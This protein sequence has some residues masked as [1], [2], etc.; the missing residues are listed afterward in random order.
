MNSPIYADYNAT[1]PLAPEAFRAMEAAGKAWGNP[2]SAHGLGREAAGLVQE[3]RE[4]I[5]EICGVGRDSVVFT[6]GGSEANSAALLGKY[7]SDPNF[8]LVTSPVEHSSI[9]DTA[10][11]LAQRSP[12]Y[13]TR[14]DGDGGLDL[15]YFEQLL[16]EKKPTLVS[17]MAANNE[18]GARFDIPT[19]ADL[20][21]NRGVLFHTDAVQ[22]LGKIPSEEWNGADLIT[23]SAH[24]IHGPKGVGALILRPG[25]QLSPLHYGGSQEVKRRGG[26]ENVSGI[27]G[28]AAAARELPQKLADQARIADLRNRFESLITEQI[29]ELSIQGQGAPRV[30]NTSNLRFEGISSEVLLSALDLDAVCISAGSACSAGSIRPSHV[31]LAMGLSTDQARECLRVSFGAGNTA[32]EVDRVADLMINHVRRIRSRAQRRTAR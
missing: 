23:V 15:E 10:A 25:V 3:A 13:Y 12:V 28:F 18:T 31:L 19:I 30:S 24:K 1:T 20:C 29:G 5:A 21:R 16:D 2:S 6:S 9:Q 22:A 17:L 26:T 7:F 4:T 8:C 32:E 27:L 14:V 11:F